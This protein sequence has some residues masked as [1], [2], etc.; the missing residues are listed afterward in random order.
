MRPVAS[1]IICIGLYWNHR[2]HMLLVTRHGKGRVML[3]DLHGLFRG[4]SVRFTDTGMS[5]NHFATVPV[6]LCGFVL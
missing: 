3:A 5:K 2:H 6:A 4:T 1:S